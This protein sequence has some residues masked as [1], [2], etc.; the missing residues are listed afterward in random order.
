MEKFVISSI[1]VP[2]FQILKKCGCLMK[3]PPTAK[4][5]RPIF[6]V[7][8]YLLGLLVILSGPIYVKT[9]DL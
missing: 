1:N 5:L 7:I 3:L 9:A 6:T 8:L 2:L 4:V